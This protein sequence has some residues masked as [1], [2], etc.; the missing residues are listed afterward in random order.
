MGQVLPLKPGTSVD[1]GRAEP[2]LS[3]R[4][5]NLKAMKSGQEEDA[6]S[7]QPH[8]PCHLA[9]QKGLG[10]HPPPKFGF[11]ATFHSKNSDVLLRNSFMLKMA[12]VCLSLATWTFD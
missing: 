6:L 2:M 10:S 8:C 9:L 12:R 11:Q 1:V 3:P 5:L 4:I 7:Q